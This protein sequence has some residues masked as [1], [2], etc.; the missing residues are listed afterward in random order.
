MVNSIEA[1]LDFRSHNE[2]VEWVETHHYLFGPRYRNYC[3]SWIK[4]HGIIN[5][6]NGNKIAGDKIRINE[7]Q[8]RESITTQGLN[9]RQ[10]AVIA[11]INDLCKYDKSFSNNDFKIY[12]PEAL[13]SFAIKMKKRYKNFVGT[14]YLPTNKLRKKHPNVLHQDLCELTFINES[15]DL[16]V[17]N[18]VFEHIPD[19]DKALTE[20]F[21][22]LS[23]NGRLIAT[24]PFRLKQ[25]KTLCKAALN[26]DG[27]I[28]HLRPAEFHGNPIEPNEGSLVYQVPG[29]DILERVK[30]AGFADACMTF[31]SSMRYG[32]LSSGANG[33]FI[34]NATKKNDDNSYL[35]RR[36]HIQNTSIRKLVCL[37][38][39]P[40]SGTTVLT[41]S[42]AAHSK[43][44]AVYEPWN[45]ASKKNEAPIT[46]DLQNFLS[47]FKINTK[48][49]EVLLV[50]E[51]AT[52]LSFIKSI[53][54]LLITLPRQFEKQ[55]IWIIRNPF[56]VY[57]SEMEAREQWW[58]L[59]G[60][61]NQHSFDKWSKKSL[62]STRKLFKQLIRQRGLVCCY[63]SIAKHPS[64]DLRILTEAI[65]LDFQ[66]KQ[67]NYHNSVKKGQ[68]AGDTNVSVN[69]K[70]ISQ[71]SID[72]RELKLCEIKATISNSE[73]YEQINELAQWCAVFEG[74][75]TIQYDNK[76]ISKLKFIIF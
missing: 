63:E 28:Q 24:F 56:H 35:S 41:A 71:K 50:K 19:L 55:F 13:S 16:V 54:H 52:K 66:D 20:I 72:T 9:S 30:N 3:I 32:I 26:K 58:G 40:R 48:N 29:W 7:K 62:I 61:I 67:L 60:K 74:M 53:A 68:V 31:Y 47:V 2:M 11:S 14:E 36:W 10:R 37:I 38:G 15:F 34:L 4:E 57:L 8:L 25:N 70:P 75:K 44:H 12:S 69:P 59:D 5:P 18:D 23:A 39:L 22:I 73:Y 27:T 46:L 64:T 43:I 42:L 49:K 6:Y 17:T 76:L 21:R 45:V 33:V 65:G 51:T 1:I